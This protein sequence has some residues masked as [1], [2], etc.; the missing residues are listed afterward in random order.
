MSPHN[1]SPHNMSPHKEKRT[2]FIHI[3]KWFDKLRTLPKNSLTNTFIMALS[4]SLICGL[5]VSV[6]V[7][8][9]KP[10]QLANI[11]Q[12]QRQKLLEIIE[13]QPNIKEFFTT[14]GAQYVE[15]RLVNLATGHYNQTINPDT[16]DQYKAERDPEHS[17]SISPI[18]DIAKLKR[19]AKYAPVY[20]VRNNNRIRFIILP[21]H[22]KGFAST[23]YGYLGLDADANTVIGLSFYQHGETPGL[24]AQVNDQLWL[25]QWHGI[26]VRDAEGKL[27]IGVARGKVA[28]DSQAANYEVDALSGA[29]W[30][31]RSVHNIVRYWLSDQGFGPY[32][33]NFSA[34]KNQ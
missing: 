14:V 32:L 7:V 31:S 13:R 30:T 6:S 8:L 11:E 24:G 19:R 25:N 2:K 9:L 17:I 16:Y 34:Q 22:G 21:I 4:I 12:E 15:V 20:L 28:A 5:I 18:D 3:I 29:T 27:R 23:L 33:K 10:I 1:M 26:K